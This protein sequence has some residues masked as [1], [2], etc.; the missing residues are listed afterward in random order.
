MTSITRSCNCILKKIQ[1][2]SSS[3]GGQKGWTG[4][5]HDTVG[6]TQAWHDMV[7]HNSMRRDVLGLPSQ[8]GRPTRPNPAQAR[9]TAE[10]AS[11]TPEAKV[12]RIVG[13]FTY[14]SYV[15]NMP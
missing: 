1:N 6:L 15:E 3:R 10:E 13:S 2:K 4:L 7:E 8:P 14:V 12:A 9:P 5:S 11:T